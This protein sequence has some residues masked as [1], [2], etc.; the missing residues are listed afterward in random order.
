[1][2]VNGVAE[3]LQ[4]KGALHR[5]GPCFRPGAALALLGQP[6]QR[7]GP[8]LPTRKRRRLFSRLKLTPAPLV[9]VVPRIAPWEAE[10]ILLQKES[11]WMCFT[12]VSHVELLVPRPLE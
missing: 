9:E 12:A 10:G 5:V 2:Q 1:M 3:V 4:T 6:G 8:P 7:Q 11:P